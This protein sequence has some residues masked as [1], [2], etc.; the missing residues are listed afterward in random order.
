MTTYVPPNK[1]QHILLAAISIAQTEG[2]INLKSIRLAKVA[3]V[4]RSLIHYH[5]KNMKSLRNA[6]IRYAK[7]H[8]ILNILRQLP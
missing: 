1:K 8:N 4:A 3:G 2:L 7:K 5:F 6:V